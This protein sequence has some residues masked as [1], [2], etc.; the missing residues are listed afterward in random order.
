[1]CEHEWE[2]L[3]DGTLDLKCKKC[4][5]RG[6]QAKLKNVTTKPL[7]NKKICDEVFK[8]IKAP[9]LRK[10]IVISTANN[11]AGRIKVYED[12]LIERLKKQIEISMGVII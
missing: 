8:P 3:E 10:T 1:M 6:Q 5:Y 9:M 2:V 7:S 4:K 11:K 12:E